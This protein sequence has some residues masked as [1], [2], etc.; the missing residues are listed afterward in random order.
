MIKIRKPLLVGAILLS[1]YAPFG[2]TVKPHEGTLDII[3]QEP[4]PSIVEFTQ[5]SYVES[6]PRLLPTVT[7]TP[8]PIQVVIEEEDYWCEEIDA[9]KHKKKVYTDYHAVTDKTSRQ[10][11]LLQLSK[12]DSR[13]GIRIVRD[14]EDEWRYCVALGNYWADNHI[15]KYVDFY[16]ANG[17]ILKCIVCDVKQDRHTMNGAR[18]YGGAA[19]ELIEFYIDTSALKTVDYWLVDGKALPLKFP[20]GDV[21]YAGEEF[22]GGISKI[23]VYNKA[24][25]GFEKNE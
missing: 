3:P 10:Y 4:T 8:I 1:I 9:T 19:N 24:L 14:N 5:D 16:M 18:K 17:A 20:A 21:S 25:E 6:A 22:M 7:P 23:K 15:G 11:A 13:T 2:G 12:T